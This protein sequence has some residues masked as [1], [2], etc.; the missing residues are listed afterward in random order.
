MLLVATKE[1]LQHA[2]LLAGQISLLLSKGEV[3]FR[4]LRCFPAF[5]PSSSV[6][7]F[8]QSLCKSHYN[9]YFLNR[10]HCCLTYCAW[11]GE[12][13]K[14]AAAAASAPQGV[15]TGL[16]LHWAIDCCLGPLCASLIV[17]AISPYTSSTDLRACISS[18][19]CSAQLQMPSKMLLLEPGAVQDGAAAD[20]V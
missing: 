3:L 18:K 1:D 11:I 9:T 16:L 2:G 7:A 19:V 8:E 14:A 12:T 13:S 17:P 5:L 20:V 10:G 4:A 6:A 15:F